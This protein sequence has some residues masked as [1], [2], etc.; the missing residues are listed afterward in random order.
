MY[1]QG[2]KTFLFSLPSSKKASLVIT[3]KITL[4]SVHKYKFSYSTQIF[5]PGRCSN[6]CSLLLD[7]FD[8]NCF[9]KYN[10]ADS[11]S[12]FGNCYQKVL[13]ESRLIFGHFFCQTRASK[14]ALELYALKSFKWEKERDMLMLIKYGND[15]KKLTKLHYILNT[16]AAQWVLI[17]L[18]QIVFQLKL[19]EHL[20][21]TPKSPP[22]GQLLPTPEDQ[23]LNPDIGYIWMV[24][25][26]IWTTV[27]HFC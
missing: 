26:L 23:D 13:P 12:K 17:C 22:S 7:T 4:R 14:H 9:C 8:G 25:N 27:T 21:I 24:L 16:S 19:L 20:K 6:Y 1:H 10:D 15:A 3:P 2:Q 18:D 5:E 11:W